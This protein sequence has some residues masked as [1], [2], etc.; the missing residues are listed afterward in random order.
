MFLPQFI[1]LFVFEP[2]PILYKNDHFI[3]LDWSAKPCG[4]S[5]IKDATFELMRLPHKIAFPT[6][7]SIVLISYC[8]L[9]ADFPL[10][11]FRIDLISL[12]Q[13]KSKVK[14]RLLFQAGFC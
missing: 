9:F 14:A 12:S 13:S 10:I 4:K 2:A 1:G 11:D 3:K 8:L 6:T 5:Q 7:I